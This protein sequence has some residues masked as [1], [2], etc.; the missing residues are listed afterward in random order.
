MGRSRRPRS[1][2]P[3]TEARGGAGGGRGAVLALLAA[4]ALAASGCTAVPSP[5]SDTA[6]AWS[7]GP[8]R[9]LLLPEEHEE[10]RR[11]RGGPELSRFLQQF[12]IRR[13]DDR[14]TPEIPLTALYAERVAAADRLYAEEDVRGALTDRGGALLL[15]GSPSILRTAQRRSP[16]WSG[17]KPP[18]GARPTRLVTLE[19][20][21]YRPEDLSPALR[22]LMGL[23]WEGREIAVVFQ[24][25][26]RHTRLIEGGDLLALAA[27]ALVHE[28]LPAPPP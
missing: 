25:G 14:A 27:R 20:W 16:T 19:I 23:G 4:A 18:P 8:V 5:A 24:V 11:I 17:A 3:S 21:A 1:H 9:W 12:W 15:L 28:P 7:E 13:D 2:P 6:R 10:L 22:E 26:T